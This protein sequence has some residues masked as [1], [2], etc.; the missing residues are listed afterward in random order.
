MFTSSFLK[1]AKTTKYFSDDPFKL[2]HTWQSKKYHT[3][4]KSYGSTNPT[5]NATISLYS[6]TSKKKTAPLKKN[7]KPKNN[8][9]KDIK[10][11]SKAKSVDFRK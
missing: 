5:K 9:N 10:I 6:F 7:P 4:Y 3:P 2:S 8:N 1:T 11:Q